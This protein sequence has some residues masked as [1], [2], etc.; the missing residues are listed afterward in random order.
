MEGVKEPSFEGDE[1]GGC[2]DIVAAG[3]WEGHVQGQGHASGPG[4][5][6]VDAVGEEE[7]FFDIVGDEDDG[8]AKGVP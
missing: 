1:V 8:L 2:D 4:G 3:S 7:G 5:E 6:D